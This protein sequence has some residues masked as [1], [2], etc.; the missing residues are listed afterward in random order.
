M[1]RIRVGSYRNSYDYTRILHNLRDK[2]E[3]KEIHAQIITSGYEQSQ[4][5]AAKLIS[6]YVEH[7][8]SSMGD[9]RRVFDCV[10]ERDVLL[11]NVIIRGYANTGPFSEAVSMFDQMR[12]SGF[13]AN[14]YTYPF[15][16]KACAVSGARIKGRLIHGHLV[17]VGLEFDLFVG[18]SLVAFYAK[19]REIE[20]SRKVFDETVVKDIVSWNSMIAGY[21]QNDFPHEAIKLFHQLLQKSTH[22]V[23]DNTTFI[24]VLPACVQEAA[25]KE[26]MW[27]HCYVIKSGMKVSAPL[28]SG[29]IAMYGN[30]GHL[31]TAR[32]LFFR[33]PERNIFVWN[34]MV[35]C[36]GMN[37]NVNDALVM[38]SEMVDS[39]IHPDGISFIS[40]LSACSHAG[41][42]DKGWELFRSMG[43]YGVEQW[44]EHYACMVDLLG[45]AGQLNEAL[46]L[47]ESMPVK[48]GKDV[49]G[50]LLGACR[51]HKNIELAE[52][53]AERLFVLDP[54][55]AGRYIILAKMYE[56]AGRWTDAAR[57]RK[58][59]L[60]FLEA[61]L[62]NK[63]GHTA[64]KSSS[65]KETEESS[66][67]MRK[68]DK[69]VQFYTKVRDTVASLRAKT[70]I[71]KKKKLRN[72]QQKLKAYDL[73][74][75]NEVLPELKDPGQ[76]HDLTNLK[77][78]SKTRQKLVEKEGR[79]L[80]AVLSNPVFQ[81]DPLAA[82][83]QHLERTQPVF[84]AEKPKKK[85]SK[86]GKKKGKKLKASSSS[87]AMDM[88][89]SS[90]D[91]DRTGLWIDYAVAHIRCWLIKMET[92]EIMNLVVW[93]AITLALNVLDI[94]LA[95]EPHLMIMT[96]S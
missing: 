95:I 60:P 43:D 26:G 85:F 25:V 22:C 4:F 70:E 50:A 13:C 51:I 44:E 83:H 2:K 56:D 9:V 72:R 57:V 61:L 39:G 81:L 17:K 38:F 5:L 79:Q 42:V 31:D 35:K 16:I 21:A 58:C 19:C 68:F 63:M 66:K 37:G 45:R 82:I 29:L 87:Q 65:S 90:L 47:I 77:L 91:F 23:P 8:D 64:L 49:Y 78:N 86:T 54:Q 74:S 76:R 18:N 93:T 33:L 75:L 28:A 27:I 3:L 71:G 6:R 69:K 52:E 34:A 11:W 89:K 73:S 48:G 20:T 14:K 15:V 67:S 10:M 36:Y 59:L 55:N 41:L 62:G 7:S 46:E 12:L 53:A 80:K 94:A 84:P 40:V 1:S 30:C 96:S 32:N 92:V 88:K 24:G